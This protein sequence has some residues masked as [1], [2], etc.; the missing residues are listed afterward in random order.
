MHVTSIKNLNL[1]L[2]IRIRVAFV[3]RFSI[4]ILTAAVELAVAK[5][6]RV[7]GRLTFFLGPPSGAVG[8][9]M[10]ELRPVPR[11]APITVCAVL[12]RWPVIFGVRIV[13]R[14]AGMA[15]GLPMDR[16]LS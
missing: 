10:P 3:S 11:I 5:A 9:R 1:R 15:Q 14:V 6:E 4:V 2:I 8:S 13:I 7:K 16:V 12:A